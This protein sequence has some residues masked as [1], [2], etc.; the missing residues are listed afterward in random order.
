MNRKRKKTSDAVTIL[1]NRYIKGDKGRLAEIEAERAR[2]NIA[3]QIYALRQERKLTQ[4]EL[5]DMMGTTQSVIS[6]FEN[7]DYENER[8]ETLQK[9]ASAL[10]CQLEVKFIPKAE[11]TSAV[12]DESEKAENTYIWRDRVSADNN[13]SWDSQERENYKFLRYG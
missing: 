5:A 11:S 9:L 8:V 7:T 4:K 13:Y 1:R 10:D 6:R 12:S 2:I 3:E